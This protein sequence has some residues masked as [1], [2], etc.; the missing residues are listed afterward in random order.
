MAPGMNDCGVWT[1]RLGRR[2]FTDV[3]GG[4]LYRDPG[5][6]VVEGYR[7]GAV[8][9]MHGDDAW[10]P[11]RISVDC[12]IVRMHPLTGTDALVIFD[13]GSGFTEADV[14]RFCSIGADD[15][16]S[17]RHGG[18]AQKRIGR[19][20]LLALGRQD[21]EE[22]SFTILTRTSR[23][24]PVTSA[25]IDTEA[26]RLLRVEHRTYE[27]DAKELGPC[28][29]RT[30]SFSA[31]IVPQPIFRSDAELRTA[32]EWRLPRKSDQ[33]GETTIG[34]KLFTP[35]PLA[36]G[37]IV[38]PDGV[39]IEAYVARTER[40]T[41]GAIWLVDA[42]TGFRVSKCPELADRIPY[43]LY[44]PDLTG[45]IFVSGLLAHQDTSRAGLAH[46]FFATRAWRQ[47]VDML[48]GHIVLPVRALLEDDDIV[49]RTTLGRLISGDVRDLFVKAYGEPDNVPGV[50]NALTAPLPGADSGS[51]NSRGSGAHPIATSGGRGGAKGSARPRKVAWKI[52]D[53]T[54]RFSTTS[55][56]PR[57]FGEANADTGIVYFN[58]AYG[59]LPKGQAAQRE[60][61][62]VMILVT[63]ARALH[64]FDAMQ[65]QWFV[66]ERRCELLGH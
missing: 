21:R 54:W 38:K 17:T 34:G 64:P 12:S 62:V 3:L 44:R 49:D 6:C 33:C 59:A 15:D 55:D 26:L 23:S 51:R 52:G 36:D 5:L 63:V 48:Q 10:D 30:G 32:I 2:L 61:A 28:R 20:A 29:N 27:A 11:R 19:I 60:H 9:C 65:A 14:K 18:A 8:A 45:D 57:V 13:G 46:R 47:V 56:D 50:E 43:P 35:P 24:G 22:R 40:G 16:T 31:I 1:M 53:R 39:P 7:N 41:Q 42:Q 4:D 37:L 58:N 66:S 25:R